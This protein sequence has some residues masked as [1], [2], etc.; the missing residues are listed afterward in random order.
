MVAETG[1]RM[2]RR[3]MLCN[4]IVHLVR[5]IR[6]DQ[7]IDRKIELTFEIKSKWKFHRSKEATGWATDILKSQCL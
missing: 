6:D 7:V 1:R 2:Y 5:Q 4:R 3:L